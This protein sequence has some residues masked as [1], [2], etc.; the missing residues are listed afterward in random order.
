MTNIQN[1]EHINYLNINWSMKTICGLIY[2]NIE[3]I[4][5]IKNK[6]T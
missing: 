2:E 4:V 5:S 1:L 6:F 3:S